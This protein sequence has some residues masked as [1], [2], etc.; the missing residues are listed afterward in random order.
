MVGVETYRDLVV[1]QVGALPVVAAICE[2]LGV[3]EAGDRFCRIRS[4]AD[5]T[6]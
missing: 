1:R 6:H 3:A 5:Y 4:V 2:R